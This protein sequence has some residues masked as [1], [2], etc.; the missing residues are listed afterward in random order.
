MNFDNNLEIQLKDN[1]KID[2]YCRQ[3]VPKDTVLLVHFFTT[4]E[5]AGSYT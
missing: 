1:F 5:V 2:I 4:S 3:K